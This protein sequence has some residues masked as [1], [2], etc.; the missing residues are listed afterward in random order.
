ME[1]QSEEQK[2]RVIRLQRVATGLVKDDILTAYDKAYKEIR[3]ILLDEFSETLPLRKLNAITKE[4]AKITTQTVGAGWQNVTTEFN[5]VAELEALFMQAIIS[6]DLKLPPIEQITKAVNSAIMNLGST[7]GTWAD[8]VNESIDDTANRYNSIIKSAWS[9][10]QLTPD[11]PVTVN[12]MMKNIKTANAGINSRQAE[13]LVRTGIVHY[14]AQS[15]QYVAKRNKDVLE[16]EVPLVV[17]DNRTSDTCIQISATYFPKG[18][19]VGESPIG[20]PPYHFSCRTV[21]LYLTKGQ[22]LLD[23]KRAV[24]GGYSGKDAKEEYLKRKGNLRTKSKTTYRGKN[25]TVFE[26][27]QVD[28]NQTIDSFLKSQPRWFVEDTLGKKKA[29]LFLKGELSLKKL[30]DATGRTLPVS[31]LQTN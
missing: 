3:L 16:R 22:K 11:N 23:G 29:D 14:S 17:F 15:R 27:E 21:I 30:T 25:D 13:T 7:A 19:P 6:E 1:Y 5:K 2:R 24:T 18:W 20:A 9:Q 4:I 28:A 8:F 10:N 31:E 26:V 12:Q